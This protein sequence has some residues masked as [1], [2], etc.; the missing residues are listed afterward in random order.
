MVRNIRPH[1]SLSTET[2]SD[3]QESPVSTGS[4]PKSASLPKSYE[5]I[6]E[7]IQRKSQDFLRGPGALL[8]RSFNKEDMY[9]QVFEYL[10]MMT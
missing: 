3:W 8:N 6:W 5:Q 9:T 4:R 2:L 10:N 1:L 7:G